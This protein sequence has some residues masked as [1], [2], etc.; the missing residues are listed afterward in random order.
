MHNHSSTTA[1][2]LADSVYTLSV[3]LTQ[4]TAGAMTNS[5]IPKDLLLNQLEEALEERQKPD[6]R[7]T[8]AELPRE[9][10]R[11]R[12]KGDR[13]QQAAERAAQSE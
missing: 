7:Q 6:R 12:R 1:S 5:I 2:N 8:N 11:D 4:T 10:V 13:R 3:N 9:V